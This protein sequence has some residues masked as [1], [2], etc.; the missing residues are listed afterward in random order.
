V[1]VTRLGTT[2]INKPLDMKGRKWGFTNPGS[3]SEGMARLIVKRTPGLGPDDVKYVATGGV[4]EGL[5]LLKRNEV[6]L[7]IFPDPMYQ[8]EKDKYKFV[9]RASDYVPKYQ[10]TMI[11]VQPEFA[12]KHP[13]IV[14]AVLVGYA[15][16]VTFIEKNPEEA[17]RIYAKI[18]ERLPEAAAIDSV[19]AAAARK[20]WNVG[21]EKEALE[22]MEESLKLADRAKLKWSEIITQ[23]YLP[24]GYRS[25]LP[26]AK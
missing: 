4:S 8:V 3:T 17:G 11:M 23:E 25:E 19:K 20:H 1:Y 5:T 10:Q 15:K 21:F 18:A 16:A 22:L 2:D 14:R 7:A 12:K 26:K 9:F 13:D 24:P 6:D